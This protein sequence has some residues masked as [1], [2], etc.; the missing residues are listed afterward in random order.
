MFNNINSQKGNL[1]PRKEQETEA[2]MD[3]GQK[4]Y[5]GTSLGLQIHMQIISFYFLMRKMETEMV[6]PT[7]VDS[8]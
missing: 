1:L 8:Y 4:L 7:A 6:T 5:I 3:K 2:Q